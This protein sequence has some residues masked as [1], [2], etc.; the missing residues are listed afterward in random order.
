MAA[1]INN[2][3]S[4]DTATPINV[5]RL[6]KYFYETNKSKYA[7]NQIRIFPGGNFGCAGHRIYFDGSDIRRLQRYACQQQPHVVPG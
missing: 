4:G 5:N 3:S 6:Q 7:T 2:P 1:T